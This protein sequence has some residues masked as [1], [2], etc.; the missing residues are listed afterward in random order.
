VFGGFSTAFDMS[1]ETMWS[2]FADGTELLVATEALHKAGPDATD[3][4]E[5]DLVRIGDEVALNEYSGSQPHL[6]ED[7]VMKASGVAVADRAV[8]GS[9]AIVLYDVEV[10]KGEALPAGT[11]WEGSS[12]YGATE[13]FLR[14][15]RETVEAAAIFAA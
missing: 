3:M 14:M 2:A 5:H 1:V 11:S 6:F 4:T 10:M 13:V 12:S 9:Y 15:E 8:I 7:R